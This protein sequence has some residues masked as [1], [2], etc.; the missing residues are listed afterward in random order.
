VIYPHPTPFHSFT[1]D[2]RHAKYFFLSHRDMYQFD[3]ISS[4]LAE[5]SFSIPFDAS[6]I[7]PAPTSAA[8]FLHFFW[9]KSA[10]HDTRDV[11]LPFSFNL[12]TDPSIDLSPF[13]VRLTPPCVDGR[14]AGRDESPSDWGNE[15]LLGGVHDFG[16]LGVFFGFGAVAGVRCP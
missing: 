9:G 4:I 7:S 11:I 8:L 15:E 6:L 5:S 14:I 2:I 3:P 1:S 16:A 10:Q 13:T 12:K